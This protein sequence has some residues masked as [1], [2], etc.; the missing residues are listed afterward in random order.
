MRAGQ[1]TC[2]KKF[3]HRKETCEERK[4][5]AEVRKKKEDSWLTRR[6]K[7][8]KKRSKR[9]TRK[10]KKK[11]SRRFWSKIGAEKDFSSE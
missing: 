9:G 5:I 3:V 4:V 10:R 2:C 1:G 11:G 7:R 6:W 8:T